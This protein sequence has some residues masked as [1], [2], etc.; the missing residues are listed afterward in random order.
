MFGRQIRPL[1]GSRARRGAKLHPFM[2]P[3]QELSRF[4]R[5]IASGGEGPPLSNLLVP[6]GQL[7]GGGAQ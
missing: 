4:L 7:G 5:S 3:F 1:A 6:R 2:E